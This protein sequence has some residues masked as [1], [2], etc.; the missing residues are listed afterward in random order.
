MNKKSNSGL[1]A[2]SH[3]QEDLQIISPIKPNPIKIPFYF[4]KT[5]EL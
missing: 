2:I 4:P 5:K 1:C 3:L